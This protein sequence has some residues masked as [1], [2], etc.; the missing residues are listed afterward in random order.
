[1]HAASDGALVIMFSDIE[2][3]TPLVERLGDDGWMVLLREH[4]ALVRQQLSAHGG[5]EV[6]SEGDGFM[7]VFSDPHRALH[8]AT[9]IQSALAARNATAEQPLRVRIGLH[10]GNC[11]REDGD[12]YGR[13]VILAS[14]IAGQAKGGEIVVSAPLRDLAGNGGAFVFDDGQDTALKG[15]S[16]THR[17]HRIELPR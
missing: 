9:A 3:H 5:H 7:V 1:M 2:G 15:L 13:N 8:C 14:R 6:K 11:V 12:F 16:G 10:A 4:N 17:I